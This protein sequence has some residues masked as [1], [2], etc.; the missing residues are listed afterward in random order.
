[1]MEGFCLVIFISIGLILEMMMM[2]M[3]TILIL[4]IS[5]INYTYENQTVVY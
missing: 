4:L 1:M 2:M 3:Y 5:T